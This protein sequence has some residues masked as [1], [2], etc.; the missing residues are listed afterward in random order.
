MNNEQQKIIE[1]YGIVNMHKANPK[2]IHFLMPDLFNAILA[3]HPQ[4]PGE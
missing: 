3:P 1:L 4:M 2:D